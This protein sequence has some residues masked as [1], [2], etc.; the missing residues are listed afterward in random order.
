M[1]TEEFKSPNF[2]QNISFLFSK[3]MLLSLKET[4]LLLSKKHLKNWINFWS[5]SMERKF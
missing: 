2:A 4:T 3:K 1:A 5:Q